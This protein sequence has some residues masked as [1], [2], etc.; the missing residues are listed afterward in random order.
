MKNAIHVFTLVGTILLEGLYHS[1]D[2]EKNSL[3]HDDRH[4]KHSV[5]SMLYVANTSVTGPLTVSMSV[6]T[7][8]SWTGFAPE[9]RAPHPP[10]TASLSGSHKFESYRQYYSSN[11]LAFH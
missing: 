9:M 10:P 1:P 2:S 8:E 11:R 4:P 5:A 3:S 7:D 6:S